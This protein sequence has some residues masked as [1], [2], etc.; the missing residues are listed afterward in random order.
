MHKKSTALCARARTH[1]VNNTGHTRK[2]SYA[3]HQATSTVC[4]RAAHTAHVVTAVRT[5]LDS[6]SDLHISG[7]LSSTSFVSLCD[8][9]LV[10]GQRV[11][12]ECFST[13][14]DSPGRR[15]GAEQYTRV[16]VRAFMPLT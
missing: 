15:A 3:T 10:W 12:V 9:L 7:R 5:Y 1:E 2:K 8:M 13:R 6:P 16:C 4:T 14:S 11:G